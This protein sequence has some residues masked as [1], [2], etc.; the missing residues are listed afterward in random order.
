MSVSCDCCGVMW[1]PLRRGDHLIEECGVSE[2]D[3]EAL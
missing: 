1:R 3:H 2:C